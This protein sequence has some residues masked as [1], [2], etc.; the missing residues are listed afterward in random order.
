AFAPRTA[1]LELTSAAPSGQSA[2]AVPRRLRQHGR[3][4]TTRLDLRSADR[5]G[6]PPMAD[7]AAVVV[8]QHLG[9]GRRSGRPPVARGFDS[10]RA[11]AAPRAT[12]FLCLLSL[13][14]SIHVCTEET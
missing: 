13:K 6:T 9:H 3:S 11:I 7:T 14:D 4:R 8:A 10:P 5:G 1:G 2:S 12:L